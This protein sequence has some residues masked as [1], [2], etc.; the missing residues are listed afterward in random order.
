[1]TILH[2]L[3]QLHGQSI[4]IDDLRRSHL[5][6]GTLADRIEQGVRGLTS[7]PTIFAKAITGSSDY[8][9]QFAGLIAAGAE[10][11]SAYWT[12]VVDDIRA[13]C[14]R[15]APLHIESG[16]GDGF[17]SVEVSPTLARDTSGT[18]DASRDLRHRVDR[19]NVMIKIPATVEGLPAIRRM[20]EEGTSV[21]VTLI[22]GLERYAAVIEAYLAGLE[23]LAADPSA[24]LASVA[25]VAS[26]FVSR[27]DT[28]VDRRLAD[29]PSAGLAGTAGLCQSR[30]AYAMFREA[31]SGPRWDALAGRGARV[32]R[33][34]WASTGTKNPAYS[35]V[36]Y[37]D[38][39][40]GPDTVNTVPTATLDAFLDHGRAERTVDG[41]PAVSETWAALARAG[42]DMGDVAAVL[43]REGLESFAASFDEVLSALTA[44][45]AK[46]RDR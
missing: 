41:D 20:I 21:N 42:V 39:L 18:I 8:D 6:D 24:D 2:E 45:A 4:W 5:H 12:M 14:D 46:L 29:S 33:P 9:V 1:M 13:A 32:Q 38:G 17:V 10:P 40:I 23:D 36:M 3:S 37:V 26:L 27:V 28:E 11:E 31:F 22:F 43:E 34:L 25:S 19:S 15:F 7:N 30:R 35:D 44:K 16:G